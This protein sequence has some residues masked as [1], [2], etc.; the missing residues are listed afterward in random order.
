[1][2]VLIA[3][4]GSSYAEAA[5]RLGAEIAQHSREPLTILTVVK[6]QTG[7][8]QA[9]IAATL[10]RACEIVGPQS[11]S[12]RTRVRVGHPATEIVREAQEGNYDLVII[13]E[14]RD[15][16]LMARF[17][18][19]STAVRVVEHAPCPVIVAKGK[20][21][22]IRRILVCDSGSRDP[23]VGLP[24]AQSQAALQG[25]GAL[26]GKGPSVL[27]RFME[28][29][30]DPFDGA[31]E[32]VVL[33]VMSQISAGPGVRGKQ[34][35]S[36]TEELLEERAPEGELLQRHIQ[37]L[38]R[39]G[40]RARAVVRHGLVVEEIL[41]EVQSGEYD[42]VVIGAYRGEGWQRIL[43]DDLAHRLVVELDRPVLV[44]R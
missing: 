26:G 43:L 11:P 9:S 34:L 27:S 32:I 3:T 13:G 38:D 4:N 31:G 17:L 29:P 15:R 22:P 41:D 12:L 40:I 42:L 30:L 44:V 6:Q 7:Q 33:H 10:A 20:I 5:L 25:I 23:S 16:N 37:A 21:G 2:P 28:L 19:G 1:M 35:R 24:P 14:R 18:H 39:L 36:S 8:P